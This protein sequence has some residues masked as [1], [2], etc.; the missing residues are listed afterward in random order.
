MGRG[1]WTPK[2]QAAGE[3]PGG[4]PRM[5]ARGRV[6]VPAGTSFAGG[7]LLGL[8]LECDLV[9]RFDLVLPSL[10]GSHSYPGV[11]CSQ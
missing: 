8:D 4:R 2:S 5:A 1:L 10:S 3:R 6:P 9:L 7:Y 11:P